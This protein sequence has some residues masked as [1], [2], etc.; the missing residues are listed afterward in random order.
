MITPASYWAETLA[1]LA[2]RAPS[3]EVD[4]LALRSTDFAD[5]YSVRLTGLGDVRL[6]AYYSVPRLT[7]P[8]PAIYH[9]PGYASVVQVPPYDER[10]RNVSLSLCARGQRLA[11]RPFA[12]AFP[13]LLTRDIDDPYRYPMRGFVAD[14]CRGF[15]FLSTRAEVDGRR[16]AVVGADM[17]LFVAALRP[18]VRA[19]VVSD[20]FMLDLYEIAT[21]GADYPHEEIADYIRLHPHRAEAVRGTLDLFNSSHLASRIAARALISCG[22]SG[23]VFD[24]GRAEQLAALIGPNAEVFER[25]GRGYLDRVFVDQW[26][27]ESISAP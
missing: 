27:E 18:S 17:A 21:A 9:A 12:A 5:C 4:H 11:D 14:T 1:E 6:F 10:R 26:V 7:G 23:S 13:G 19:V 25:S 3:P 24:R 2:A 22:P 20:P 15:D 8:R 16:I